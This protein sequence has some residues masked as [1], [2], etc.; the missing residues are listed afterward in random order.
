M[1]ENLGLILLEGHMEMDPVKVASVRD[2]LTPRNVTKV[3]SFVGFVDFYRHFVQDF[4]HVANH[5]TNSPR[6]VKSGNGL[7]R[8]KH[9]SRNL[10]VS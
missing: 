7:T 1:V 3:Q 5:S 9:P 6:R 4:S 2:W 10:N 8:S